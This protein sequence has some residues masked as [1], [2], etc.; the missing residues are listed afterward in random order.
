MRCWDQAVAWI[1]RPAR[2]AAFDAWATALSAARRA[3]AA[4]CNAGPPPRERSRRLPTVREH[5]T[6]VFAPR[7]EV[8]RK[9]FA[10]AARTPR[11]P[12][13]GPWHTNRTSQGH[14]H[15][16]HHHL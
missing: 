5:P 4:S 15:S 3:P 8:R 13:D 12:G 9:R 10:L 7:N 2:R 16:T 14:D 11:R 6:E 1:A